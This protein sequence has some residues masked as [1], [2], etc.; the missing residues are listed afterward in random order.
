MWFGLW[1]AVLRFLGGLSFV[2]TSIYTRRCA[3]FGRL[4]PLFAVACRRSAL[5]LDVRM[6][7]ETLRCSGRCAT[8]YVGP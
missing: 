6:V 2:T 7:M 3:P 1:L 4:S 5:L 8:L